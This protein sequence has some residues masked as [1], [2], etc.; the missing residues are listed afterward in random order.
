MVHEF[1]WLP[2]VVDAVNTVGLGHTHKYELVPL[3]PSDLAKL[4]EYYDGEYENCTH[5]LIYASVEAI[6]GGEEQ[7]VVVTHV[8]AADGSGPY[9]TSFYEDFRPNWEAVME[10]TVA[11]AKSGNLID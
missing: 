8:V 6:E 1:E 3:L 4:A 7:V 9:D 10:E 2:G 11:K 5:A